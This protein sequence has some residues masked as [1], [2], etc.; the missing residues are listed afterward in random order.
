MKKRLS[1]CSPKLCQSFSTPFRMPLAS[2]DEV[3]EAVIWCSEVVNAEDLGGFDFDDYLLC[4][5]LS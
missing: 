1:N 3:G 2:E 5:L 4:V